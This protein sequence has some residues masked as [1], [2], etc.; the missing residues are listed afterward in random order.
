MQLKS[1]NNTRIY[2][3]F[4][5]LADIL[6]GSGTSINF[7]VRCTNNFDKTSTYR[8][9]AS[10]PCKVDFDLW[11]STLDDIQLL[12]R[13]QHKT[14]GSWFYSTHTIPQCMF[15]ATTNT[16]FIKKRHLSA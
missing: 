10:Q 12:L 5:S 14:L 3:K 11:N 2:Y 16:V 9:P 15:D 4:Y 1:I 8:W 13:K 7:S 6:T